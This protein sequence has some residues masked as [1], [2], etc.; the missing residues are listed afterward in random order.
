MA[1]KKPYNKNNISTNNSKTNSTNN[2]KDYHEDIQRKLDRS[3]ELYSLVNGWIEKTDNKVNISIAISS[4]VVGLITFISQSFKVE[5]LFDDSKY[6]VLFSIYLFTLVLSVGFWLIAV[7][8]H[9]YTI[10]PDL[11]SNS[12]GKKNK[13]N[14]KKV[15]PIF[16]KDIDGITLNEYIELM[17]TGSDKQFLD[18]L[19]ADIHQNS[20]ICTQKMKRFSVGITLSIVSFI[21]AIISLILHIFLFMYFK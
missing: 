19:I 3:W 20:K 2:N 14:T 9:L 11:T 16:F 15:Y 12:N 8:Y 21:I 4:V 17:K 1:T 18:E 10:K 7:I 5:P 13:K 6:L